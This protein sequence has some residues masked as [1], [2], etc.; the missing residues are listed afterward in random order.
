MC[1]KKNAKFLGNNGGQARPRPW[2]HSWNSDIIPVNYKWNEVQR[3]IEI[4]Q[5]EL[6]QTGR[7]EGFLDEG[8]FHL[9]P[10][11]WIGIINEKKDIHGREN[12]ICKGPH[13]ERVW[14]V[15]GLEI[16]VQTA[17]W[18]L[19]IVRHHLLSALAQ[20][21]EEDDRTG[22]QC[23]SL[24]LNNLR[25][26]SNWIIRDKDQASRKK[27]WEKGCVWITPPCEHPEALIAL[28]AARSQHGTAQ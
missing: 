17:G 15:W 18:K 26:L 1:Q 11:G 22:I 10:E 2:P 12:R 20:L 3:S 13:K 7:V 6:T 4:I 8:M 21:W 9:E 14:P 24:Q 23:P 19:G 16:D 5:A 27:R 28:E 25:T